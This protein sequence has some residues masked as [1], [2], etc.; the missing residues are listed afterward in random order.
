MAKAV[1]TA[2][3]H[4]DRLAPPEDKLVP[5]ED[6]LISGTAEKRF[7]DPEYKKPG[8]TPDGYFLMPVEKRLPGESPGEKSAVV[9]DKL[10]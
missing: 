1:T 8:E 10:A 4:E 9:E 7:V 3:L 5:T 6:K 2:P